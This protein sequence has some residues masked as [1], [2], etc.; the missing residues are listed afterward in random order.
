VCVYV[1]VPERVCVHAY[2][3]VCC[4]SI[5]VLCICMHAYLFVCCVYMCVCKCASV[6]AS[7]RVR[8]TV[9]MM[10]LVC[11]QG[12]TAMCNVQSTAM[13]RVGQNRICTPYMT[14]YL[15]VFLP[16]LPYIHRICMVLANPS[17]VQCTEYCYVQRTE[18]CYVQYTEYFQST[19]HVQC[20]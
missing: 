4:V 11:R 6:R 5:R 12:G 16:K 15:V 2:L 9:C 7:G 10:L 13:C 3:Y 17:Y 14:V 19:A 1:C 8:E 18:Y 20:V